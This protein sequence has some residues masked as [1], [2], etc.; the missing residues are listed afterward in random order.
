MAGDLRGALQ[1]AA[2]G[3]HDDQAGPLSPPGEMPTM[4]TVMPMSAAMPT[5][6]S[7]PVMNWKR[8]A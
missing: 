6:T 7:A 1:A 3:F 8:G 2:V 4:A 5:A